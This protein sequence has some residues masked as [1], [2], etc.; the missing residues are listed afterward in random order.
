VAH[1]LSAKKRVRQNEKI[2]KYNRSYKAELKT[3]VKDFLK[4]V[5]HNRDLKAAETALPEAYKTI[6]KIAAKGVIHKKTAARRK[7]RL[8]RLV[9]KMKKAGTISAE[10]K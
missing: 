8:A 7:S 4:L 3:E 9:S 5:H 6:D 1:S 2:N 10:T